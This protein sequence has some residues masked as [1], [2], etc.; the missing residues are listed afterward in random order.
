MGRFVIAAFRP[1]T[2]QQQ[3]LAAMVERHWRALRAENLV[4]DRPCYV[5]QAADGTIVEVFEW[6]SPEAVEAA[7][8]NPAVTDLWAEFEAACDYIP[9]SALPES[10]HP[11]SEF[12]ALPR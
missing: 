3:A 4:T 8:R 1:K 5:M 6:R 12:E 2:G 9:V 7:H 10:Q 11:F